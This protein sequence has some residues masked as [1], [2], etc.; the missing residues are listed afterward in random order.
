M[1]QLRYISPSDYISDA[2][3]RAGL[4]FISDEALVVPVFAIQAML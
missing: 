1:R 2:A 3:P 4:G